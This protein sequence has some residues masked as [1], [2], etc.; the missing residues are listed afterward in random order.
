[1]NAETELLCLG[2]ALLLLLGMVASLCVRCSHPGKG[3][4]MG[5]S[6]V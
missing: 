6:W 2:A 3:G 1:M 5:G 4:T